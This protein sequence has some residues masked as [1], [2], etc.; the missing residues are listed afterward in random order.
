MTENLLPPKPI[1]RTES[2]V[3]TIRASDDFPHLAGVP[4]G[5]R[6]HGQALP[7]YGHQRV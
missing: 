3:F 4:G 6:N 2:S 7:Q 5:N 1:P